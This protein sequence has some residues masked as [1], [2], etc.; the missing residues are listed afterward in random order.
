M[1]LRMFVVDDMKNMVALLQ[2]LCD[3]LGQLEIAGTTGTEAEAIDWLERNPRAWDVAVL[4]LVL[5]QGSGISL[6]SRA[7]LANPTGQ[8][9]VFS[10]YTSA[11]LDAHC[12]ELGAN[13]VF[14]KQDSGAFVEWL[15]GLARARGREA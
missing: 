12:R 5:A 10:S 1:A 4:D 6:V 15:G 3:S 9:V 11:G 13:A 7:R 2:D 14:N 8:I